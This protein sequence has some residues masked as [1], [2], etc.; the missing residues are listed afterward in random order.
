VKD[1]GARSMWAALSLLDRQ[2][3]D[4]DGLHAGKVDDVEF[5]LAEEAGGLPVVT[6]L[7]QGPIALGRRLAGWMGRG[8]E[9]AAKRLHPDRD[10]EPS[11]VA[12]GVVKE[13][14]TH[15]E[16][17]IPRADLPPFRLEDWLRER[18]V[19]RIPGAGK[20]EEATPTEQQR[21]EIET[22]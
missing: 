9:S 3:I 17:S 12:L 5:Q 7:L 13:I 18:V 8:I 6:S 21:H 14:G 15:V 11:R 1:A 16:L 4:Q 20:S 10:P 2:I 19:R 22:S